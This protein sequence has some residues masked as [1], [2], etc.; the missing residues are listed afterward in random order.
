MDPRHTEIL[1]KL[2]QG[3]VENNFILK[4]LL[5][6][7]EA[8][9]TNQKVDSSGGDIYLDPEFIAQFPISN[10]DNYKFVENQIINEPEYIQKLVPIYNICI[11]LLTVLCINV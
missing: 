11:Q 5:A 2:N 8:M 10:S 6:K 1:E 4:R 3:I 9:E 7:V